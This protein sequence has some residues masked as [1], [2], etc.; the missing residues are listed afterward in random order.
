MYSSYLKILQNK[1]QPL[2]SLISESIG[3]DVTVVDSSLRRIS[4]TGAF[5]SRINH[6]CPSDSIFQ[7][8]L[9]TKQPRF[10][11]DTKDN[12]ICR[13]CSNYSTCVEMQ[14]ISFPILVNTS[15][16]G[17]A[18]LACFTE[19]Q[20][21]N[22]QSQ[23]QKA[24][25]LL[26]YMVGFITNE[27]NS[28]EHHNKI[29]ETTAEIHE[30]INSIDK[31]II[32]IDEDDVIL[33]L[34]SAAVSL[35]DFRISHESIIG[36]PLGSL[37]HGI[38]LTIAEDIETSGCWD[39][40]RRK[41]R[42]IYKMNRLC[43]DD[44]AHHRIITFETVEEI[45]NKAIRY[46]EREKI[47]FDSI[48]GTSEVIQQAIKI[49]RKAANGDSTI[50][51]HGE[52]GTGKELFAQ[53]IHNESYRRNKP[54]VMVNCA[55]IPESLIESEFFGYERG[56]FTGA[57]PNGRTGKFEAADGGTIFLDEVGEIPLHL[58]G[59]LLRVI[60][61]RAVYRIGS[62]ER[63]EVN[64]RIIAASNRNLK[65]MVDQKNFRED[66]FYRLHVIPIVLPPLRE[67]GEDIITLSEYI[68]H[69]L[70]YKM[71]KDTKR[72]SPEVQ[73]LFRD[74][75]WPGNIRE[76]ENVIEYAINFCDADEIQLAHLP[77]CL[78]K[79][80]G[81]VVEDSPLE[82][83]R[84]DAECRIIEEYLSLYGNSTEAKRKIARKLNI[85]LTTLYRR[86]N[87]LR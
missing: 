8:V 23:E 82:R 55:G 12:E 85:S 81:K 32:I 58:Q 51:L 67:R 53:S 59:K 73:K 86:L 68:V 66:L 52:S 30:I 26:N 69:R 79:D 42:V 9:E 46:K 10:N 29:I 3:V 28:I 22:L 74:Y 61:E 72:L 7:Q 64:I 15:C 4:G 48:V 17:V 40:R 13:H 34:N 19:K 33:H 44:R 65:E 62:N 75:R 20:N 80:N 37:V 21:K 14:N 36:H 1:I 43:I 6:T 63:K 2:T 77:D 45:V 49:A 70:A 24:I 47:V 35:L 31:G 18:S 84:A 71:N 50:L 57:D 41:Y 78:F 76:L 54:F 38:T 39:T 60:Q 27:V 5:Y 25:A 87:A 83:V 56:A 16:I 11:R